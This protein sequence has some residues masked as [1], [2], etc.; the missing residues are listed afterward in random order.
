MPFL[1]GDGTNSHYTFECKGRGL[2]DVTVESVR[3]RVSGCDQVRY[4]KGEWS[5]RVEVMR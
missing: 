1:F 3:I 5:G 2:L 4:S